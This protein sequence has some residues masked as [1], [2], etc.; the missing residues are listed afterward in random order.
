MQLVTVYLNLRFHEQVTVCTMC[1]YFQPIEFPAL[2]MLTY[3]K[4]DFTTPTPQNNIKYQPLK[5]S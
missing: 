5:Q 2:V 1:M 3:H 4:E